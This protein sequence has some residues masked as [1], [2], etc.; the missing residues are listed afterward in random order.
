VGPSSA[1]PLRSTI[2]VVKKQPPASD[3]SLALS[4]LELSPAAASLAR[5]LAVAT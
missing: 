5:L 4:V 1:S 3:A 2:A